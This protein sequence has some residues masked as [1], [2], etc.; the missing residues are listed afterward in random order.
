[1][2]PA[3]SPPPRL[4]TRGRQGRVRFFACPPSQP[5]ASQADGQ[6]RRHPSGLRSPATA[7]RHSNRRDLHAGPLSA[8]LGQFHAG[9]EPSVEVPDPPP[10]SAPSHRRRQLLRRAAALERQLFFIDPLSFA[11]LTRSSPLVWFLLSARGAGDAYHPPDRPASV[12]AVLP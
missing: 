11:A 9:G 6:I 8:A 7:L 4:G 5:K 2:P 10:A 12:D 1:M 3:P